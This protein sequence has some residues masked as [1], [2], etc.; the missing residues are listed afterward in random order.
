MLATQLLEVALID[1]IKPDHDKIRSRNRK[2]AA[3]TRSNLK[4]IKTETVMINRN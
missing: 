3:L 1:L 2:V 4:I